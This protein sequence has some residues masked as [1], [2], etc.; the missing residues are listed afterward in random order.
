M[1]DRVRAYIDS[2][3]SQG[4]PETARIG[5]APESTAG[6]T[7]AE[8]RALVTEHDEA[9]ALAA[10]LRE[11]LLLLRRDAPTYQGISPETYWAFCVHTKQIADIALALTPPAAL[12]EQRKREAEIRRE[13]ALEIRPMWIIRAML[14]EYDQWVEKRFPFVYPSGPCA[15]AEP[16]L[17]EEVLEAARDYKGTEEE[18]R[19]QAISFAY[20]N[21]LL[22]GCEVT[23]EGIAEA[24]DKL[25]AEPKEGSNG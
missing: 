20:G 16:S 24:Y 17:I 25:A 7:L 14:P 13:V 9:L 15:D 4:I 5:Y 21:L 12:D 8:L 19:S 3:A 11:T 22:D 18:K 23:K 10:K 1:S 2:C 6:I